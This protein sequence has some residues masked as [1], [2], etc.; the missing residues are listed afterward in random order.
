MPPQKGYNYRGK[1]G[2]VKGTCEG[3]KD[4][5]ET[6]IGAII[7]ASVCKKED[8]RKLLDFTAQHQELDQ[9]S[10]MCTDVHF[11]QD[12][13]RAAVSKL[14]GSMNDDNHAHVQQAA[15]AIYTLVKYAA[16]E[17]DPETLKSISESIGCAKGRFQLDD[18]LQV[19]EVQTMNVIESLVP[20]PDL[21]TGFEYPPF[22][23]GLPFFPDNAY[24]VTMNLARRHVSEKCAKNLLKLVQA[25]DG[26]H[27]HSVCDNVNYR[28]VYMRTI[29]W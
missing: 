20:I 3:T 8:V 9:K 14:L 17:F 27:H 22:Q 13:N 6:E 24:Q 15:L 10:P 2:T 18:F 12:E 11:T 23:K 29:I 19:V 28:Q 4:E 25:V 5:W 21:A 7:V 16:R 26:K 1:F